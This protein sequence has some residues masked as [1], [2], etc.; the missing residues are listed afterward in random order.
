MPL[1]AGISCEDLPTESRLFVE[2]TKDDRELS[3]YL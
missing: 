3:D 2:T 1:V